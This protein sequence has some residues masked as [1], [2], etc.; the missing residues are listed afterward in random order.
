ME[1]IVFLQLHLFNSNV[2]LLTDS[3]LQVR[4]VHFLYRFRTDPLK[5]TLVTSQLRHPFHSNGLLHM[6]RPTESPASKMLR[7]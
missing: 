4:P 2:L 3:L 5:T 7:Y 6:D 1:L